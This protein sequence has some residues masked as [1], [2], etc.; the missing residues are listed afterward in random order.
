MRTVI[1]GVA[2][3][4]ILWGFSFSNPHINVKVDGLINYFVAKQSQVF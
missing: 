3:Y 1:I 2:I 4:L